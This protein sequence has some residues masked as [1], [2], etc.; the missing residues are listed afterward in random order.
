MIETN[1][2]HWIGSK[3][4]HGTRLMQQCYGT[5]SIGTEARGDGD[6]S[7]LWMSVLPRHVRTP[8]R[9]SRPCPALLTLQAVAAPVVRPAAL[10]RLDEVAPAP[11]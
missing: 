8:R 10:L 5:A 11:V 3:L 4:C 7:T 9:S 1:F 6:V 2:S